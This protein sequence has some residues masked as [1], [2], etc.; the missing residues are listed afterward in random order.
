MTIII[1]F[2]FE[3]LVWLTAVIAL[4]CLTWLTIDDIRWIKSMYYN[5]VDKTR[6]ASTAWTTLVQLQDQE[7][8]SGPPIWRVR[9]APGGLVIIISDLMSARD[10]DRCSLLKPYPDSAI[11]ESEQFPSL[12]WLNGLEHHSW[13]TF[14]K[15]QVIHPSF[16]CQFQL[17]RN[18]LQLP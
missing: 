18:R 1:D 16:C 8:Q 2:Q 17:V 7:R 14:E 4:N 6:S 13:W 12:I 3:L 11:C 15:I 5:I 9:E 10:S